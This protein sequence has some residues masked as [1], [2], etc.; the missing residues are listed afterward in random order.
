MRYLE[1]KG[2]TNYIASG[3]GRDFMR[4]ITSPIY[5]IPPERVIGRA[6]GLSYTED[7]GEGNCRA[8]QPTGAISVTIV[9]KMLPTHQRRSQA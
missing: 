6:L 5:G 7:G 3:G 8:G 1:A 4:P 9:A 2:F